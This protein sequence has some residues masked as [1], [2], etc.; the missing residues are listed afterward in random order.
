M[1]K[2]FGRQWVGKELTDE[3][4]TGPDAARGGSA[5]LDAIGSGLRRWVRSTPRLRKLVEGFSPRR[6]EQRR[7]LPCLNRGQPR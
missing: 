6:L 1:V 4:I 2:A 7:H 3:H 5:I